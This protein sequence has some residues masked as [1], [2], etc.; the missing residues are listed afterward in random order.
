M[1]ERERRIIGWLLKANQKT[2]TL[3]DDASLAT[4][5]VSRGILVRHLRHGQI[6]DLDAVPFSF[7]DEVWDVL[8]ERR[9][10]FIEPPDM[11]GRPPWIGPI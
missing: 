10:E 3:P 2:V 5:L 7:P 9:S 1:T 8:V 11:K 6:F 4:T